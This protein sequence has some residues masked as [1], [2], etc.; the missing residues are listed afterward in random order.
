MS[1]HLRRKWSQAFS[2][3]ASSVFTFQRGAVSAVG[4]SFSMTAVKNPPLAF[5]CGQNLRVST[6]RT[7]SP[8]VVCSAEST[9][10]FSSLFSV[11]VEYSRYPPGFSARNALSIRDVCRR[12]RERIF[13]ICQWASVLLS[14]HAIPSPEHGASS[15]TLSNAFDLSHHRR[16]SSQTIPMGRLPMRS[17]LSMSC[18]RRSFDDSL[19]SMKAPGNASV[20]C[21]VLPPGL[22]ARSRMSS[23]GCFHSYARCRVW[24][25][26]VALSSW[27]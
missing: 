13:L 24:T 11:Q 20:S 9:P 23:G 7:L 18:G 6:I 14:F 21:V 27:M 5:S 16:P 26:C 17:V 25:E 2:M 1:R 19:A 10:S 15:R 3:I 8:K 22:A 12:A 4:A